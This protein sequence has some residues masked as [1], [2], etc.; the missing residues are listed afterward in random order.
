[1]QAALQT[2]FPN[3][4]ICFSAWFL[5]TLLMMGSMDSMDFN[6]KKVLVRVDF[7]V[8]LDKSSHTITDDTRIRAA[9]PTIRAILERQGAVIL[10]SHLGRPKG[11]P[12]T[13][14]SLQHVLTHLSSLLNMPVQFAADCAG[15]DSSAKAARLKAGEVLLLENLRFHPDEEA[16]DK[17]FA[18]KL[19]SLGEVYVNDA[20]GAAHR[21]H[22][23][24][25]VIAEFIPESNRLFGYLMEAEVQSATRVIENA[26]QPFTAI[27][28]GAKVSDKLLVIENLMNTASNLLIGGGMA[29]TFWRALKGTTGKSLCEESMLETATALIAKAKQKGVQLL[30]PV[31]SV[32][33]TSLDGNGEPRESASNQIPDGWM[34]LDI[35]PQSIAA[36]RKTILA[37]ATI[38]WNGPMGV[39]ENEQFQRGTQE[40]ALAVA[41]ATKHGAYSL[42]GGGDS[43][44]ALKKFGLSD[45]VSHVSTGGGALLEMFEGKLLPGIAAIRAGRSH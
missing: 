8:P 22:A 44:A 21:A 2:S 7:N 31:D 45:S 34:G 20:F 39:F 40:I 38:L 41:E 12:D 28:G 11:K 10:M 35:G 25:A 19:A 32:I 13:R 43:V 29:Y 6:G 27:L 36:F 9:L 33:S 5:K 30:L 26:Q 18:Q 17:A 23:S 16:G 4:A 42:V 37:S 1:M 24:T 14:Y 3:W 15:P